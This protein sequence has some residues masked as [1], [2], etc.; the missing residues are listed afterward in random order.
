VTRGRLGLLGFRVCALL[1]GCVVAGCKDEAEDDY[2][3]CDEL[4]AKGE[5]ESALAACQTARDRSP[6][7]EFG[8]KAEERSVELASRLRQKA[9]Q[10]EPP[11]DDIAA[12]DAAAKRVRQQLARIV[13]EDHKAIIA[14]LEKRLAEEKDEDARA[15]L[16]VELAAAKELAEKEKA[17][18]ELPP[19][20]GGPA[21]TD[22][23]AASAAASA[24]P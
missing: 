9:S 7:S 15:K 18:F 5:V 21:P 24:S 6:E 1:V 2:R 13:E 4:A 16:E 23:P 17:K 12:R 10:A 14:D 11:K 8:H 22:P 3:R 19:E 20:E